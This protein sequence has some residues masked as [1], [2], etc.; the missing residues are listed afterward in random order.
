[1]GS[2]EELQGHTDDELRIRD[3]LFGRGVSCTSETE[4]VRRGGTTFSI[5]IACGRPR[6][7]SREAFR[8]WS[9]QDSS[10]ARRGGKGRVGA[11]HRV[12]NGGP[13]QSQRTAEETWIVRVL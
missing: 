1:M 6:C 13:A 7:D 10:S 3:G 5:R 2:A 4:P 9:T 12:G 8:K 11:V